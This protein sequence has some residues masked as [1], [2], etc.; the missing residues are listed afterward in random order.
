VLALDPSNVFFTGILHKEAPMFLAE[1]L[2][3]LG[4]VRM[5]ARRDLT[6]LGI[7]ALGTAIA[8]LTRPYAGAALGGAGALTV[9][10]AALRRLGPERR[11]IPAIAA[12]VAVVTIAAVAIGPS[13]S[14]AL[15]RIQESQNANA[16]DRSNLQLEPVDFSS[17]AAVARSLPKRTFELLFR[18][19]PWQVANLS[20]QLG[21]IGTTAAWTLLTFT[22]AALIRRPRVALERLPP[23]IYVLAALTIGYALSTGNAGTGFRYRTHLL[24]LLA[25]V[26]GALLGGRRR[27]RLEMPLR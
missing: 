20:Q 9:A 13:P 18:P 4:A 6:A 24:V 16:S 2:V 11:R 23:F 25:A 14:A 15:E 17:P 12:G 8:V 21:V 7:I 26:A 10:H 22:L 19:F 27:R 3:L 1:G 5:Y